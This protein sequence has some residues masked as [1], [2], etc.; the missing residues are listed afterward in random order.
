MTKCVHEVQ[1]LTRG[2]AWGSL[3]PAWL[4]RW[5]RF[6]QR[7]GLRGMHVPS[8]RQ[9]GRQV[10]G[11]S[12]RLWTG[13]RWLANG[14]VSRWH[15]GRHDLRSADAAEYGWVWQDKGIRVLRQEHGRLGTL[16][17][18]RE[19]AR[20]GSASAESE[21]TRSRR[22]PVP[23]AQPLASSRTSAQ[24]MT[25][26][27]SGYWWDRAVPCRQCQVTQ[28]GGLRDSILPALTTPFAFRC[29]VIINLHVCITLDIM[30]AMY[31]A[32]KACMRF[33]ADMGLRQGMQTSFALSAKSDRLMA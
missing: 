13:K 5:F 6:C 3:G 27:G 33:Q 25:T 24:H 16:A 17:A 12:G 15:R 29:L 22:P 32:Q 10:S 4:L 11:M 31:P 30:E 2:G 21:A 1:G 26:R 14:R 8:C 18:R 9:P 19:A 20:Y 23:L 28:V 7:G